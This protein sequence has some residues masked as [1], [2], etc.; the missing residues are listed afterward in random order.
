MASR[1]RQA[2][3]DPVVTREPGGTPL[4]ERVRQ[5]FLE[6]GAAIDPLAEAFLVNASRAQLVDDVIAPALRAGRLVLSD[7]FATATLAYQG[8]GR[9]VD[10]DILRAIGAIATRGLEPDVVLLIDV[11]VELSR[12]RLARRAAGDQTF[13]DRLEREDGNFH[14]RVREG[15]LE[16]SRTD[17]HILKLDGTL[18]P[19]ALLGSACAALG[20]P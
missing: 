10:R 5:I 6:P 11:P 12:Q 4:G 16:L 18:E 7:R 19:A 9:G 13:P 20:L 2:G 1:L 8:F 17:A 3:I 14:A 15:Y